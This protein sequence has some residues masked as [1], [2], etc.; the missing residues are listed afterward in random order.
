MVT[1]VLTAATLG[2]LRVTFGTLL[3]QRFE[4]ARIVYGMR[5][6]RSHPDAPFIDAAAAAD[7]AADA[8]HSV[9]D[10]IHARGRLRVGVF[11]DRLPYAFVNREGRLTGLDVEMAH[12]LALDLGV[13]LDFIRLESRADL[14]RMLTT[15]TVDV[16][17][18]GV[19]VTPDRAT[20]MLFSEPYL[21][22][23]LAFVVKDHLREEF[24]S[25]ARIRELGAFG[26]VAPDVPY[27][28][29]AVREH[30]PSLR[31]E[32]EDIQVIERGFER[33]TFDAV[34]LPAE[35]G[36]VRTLLYPQYSVV[37]PDTDVVRIPLAYPL[38]RGDLGFASFI[39]TWI[40]LK[41]R[42]GTIDALHQHWILG[43]DSASRRPRW[44]VIRDVLHW[45]E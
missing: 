45:V 30:A 5:P 1:V 13:A 14:P 29:A 33:G 43:R 37:V 9:L 41:R 4:G 12:Q 44:S 21:D 27:Y 6:L 22:E 2:G 8:G 18:A 17:M 42:D 36:S 11:T 35:S 10:A 3:A 25:W 28:L 34:I 31:L 23:T 20:Q 15:D 16:V 40:E 32:V 7:G 26:V 24:S 38:A 39:N 19:P